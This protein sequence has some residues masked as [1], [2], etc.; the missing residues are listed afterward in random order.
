MGTVATDFAERAQG[1][2]VNMACVASVRLTGTVMEPREDKA[3]WF[4]IESR[5]EARRGVDSPRIARGALWQRLGDEVLR[6]SRQG[7]PRAH[8]SGH[9]VRR[10]WPEE[11][12]VRR[13]SDSRQQHRP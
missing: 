2:L 4:C 12:C 8:Q 3:R 7:V 6:A 1:D 13:R 10:R 5:R 11:T 9:D